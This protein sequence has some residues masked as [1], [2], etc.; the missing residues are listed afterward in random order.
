MRTV[1]DLKKYAAV[2]LLD[3]PRLDDPEIEALE[4]YVKSGGG[5][6]F[7]LGSKTDRTH[8]NSK[9]FREGKGFFPAP[10]RLPTQLLSLEEDKRPDITVVKHPIFKIVETERN[11][12]LQLMLVDMYYDLK[13]DWKPTEEEQVQTIARLRNGRPLALEKTFGNGRV[14]AFLSKASP[15]VVAQGRWN[16]CG[17]NPAYPVIIND[18]VG[19]LGYRWLNEKSL[20][21]GDTI[22]LELPEKDFTP[23]V[24]IHLTNFW[25]Q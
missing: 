3:V 11:S 21:V 14:F 10:L 15:E 17:M 18:L 12:F 24:A 13:P 16:N 6:A 8:V 5:V 20:L 19:H 23:I 7:F 22:N 2:L 1:K 4:A 25:R 9:W